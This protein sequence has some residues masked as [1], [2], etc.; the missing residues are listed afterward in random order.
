MSKSRK[1]SKNGEREV[2]VFD[3]FRDPT[4]PVH[5]YQEEQH[6]PVP[7]FHQDGISQF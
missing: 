7:T 2:G 1:S 6:V 4:P 3:S 5:N